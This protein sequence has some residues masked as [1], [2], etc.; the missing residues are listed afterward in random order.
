MNDR[1]LDSRY[2][3]AKEAFEDSLEELK[4]LFDTPESG[5][6]NYPA[7]SENDPKSDRDSD[8]PSPLHFPP[9]KDEAKSLG[10][11][12]AGERSTGGES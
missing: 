5:M 10:N 7:G 2:S 1:Q 12:A 8:L 9:P 4:H 3:S 6:E 11:G